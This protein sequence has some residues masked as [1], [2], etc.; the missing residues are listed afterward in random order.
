M[1]VIMIGT[2]VVCPEHFAML[3]AVGMGFGRSFLNREKS[4]KKQ[5]WQK[6]F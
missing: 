1:A 4:T 5:S 3:S 2:D 6:S